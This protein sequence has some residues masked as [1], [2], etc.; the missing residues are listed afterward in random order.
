MVNALAVLPEELGFFTAPTQ[1]LTTFVTAVLEDLLSS[2]VLHRHKTCMSKHPHTQNTQNLKK[3]TQN[4]TLDL[5][6][7]H[8]CK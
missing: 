2:S 5:Y 4:P 7:K 6:K 3:K 8:K 1:Q